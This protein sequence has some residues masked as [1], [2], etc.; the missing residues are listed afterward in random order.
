M[1]RVSNRQNR[2]VA[3]YTGAWIEI[4]IKYR[5]KRFKKSHPTRVRG[6]KYILWHFLLPKHY[7][8]PYTGAWIEIVDAWGNFTIPA[9]RTLHGCVDWN[10]CDAIKVFTSLR[11]TLHGCVDWNSWPSRNIC[12]PRVAPYTGAWIEIDKLSG[13]KQVYN[14]RTLH[15]C[16]D[17]NIDFSYTKT[18][19]RSHPTRVRGLK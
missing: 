13:L 4:T 2:S 1:Q 12:S 5:K 3:P 11:R 15:G 16:V 7:V 9:R 10:N 18:K 19:Y 14:R 6:L 8:A 17:W